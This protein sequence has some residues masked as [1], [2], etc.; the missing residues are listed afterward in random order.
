[1]AQ[2]LIAVQWR[3]LR[4][5]RA[6]QTHSSERPG[7][8]VSALASSLGRTSKS[9]ILL[10][11]ICSGRGFRSGTASAVHDFSL[12]TLALRPRSFPPEVSQAPDFLEALLPALARS[13]KGGFPPGPL[14]RPQESDHPRYRRNASRDD[15]HKVKPDGAPS[16]KLKRHRV[17]R[18]AAI[19]PPILGLICYVYILM[20]GYAINLPSRAK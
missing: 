20:R 19:G 18:Y 12:R 14:R 16:S 6:R 11:E 1:M 13:I 15:R 4:G 17:G 8:D 3:R 9:P 5:L 7:T 10:V 2:A